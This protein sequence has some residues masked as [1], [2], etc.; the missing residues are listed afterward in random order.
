MRKVTFSMDGFLGVISLNDPP[1]N[2]LGQELIDDLN[3]LLDQL[4][5]MNLRGLLLKSGEG[6]F[7]AGANMNLFTGLDSTGGRK[8]L[9]NFLGIIHK[10]ECLPYPTLAA[11]KGLCL[12]G[13]FELA[14]ACDLIWASSNA[15]FGSPEATIATIP[16]GA[17]SRGLAARAGIARAKEIVYEA[18]FYHAESMEKWNIV[19]KV[20]ADSELNEK[21]F[22]YMKTLSHGPTLAY[23]VTKKLSREYFNNGQ[24]SSDNMLLEI[25]PALFETSDF[26]SG[27][28]SLLENG[29]GHAKFYA[30]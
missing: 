9:D 26:I 4:P 1:F 13:G 12:G 16:L 28:K 3:S 19:N 15:K 5:D 23:D 18:K 6:N 7:S 10:I 24:N 27:V 2:L 8:L 11:V 22:E 29:P 21:A 14:L 20:L 17:G 30:K 25:V